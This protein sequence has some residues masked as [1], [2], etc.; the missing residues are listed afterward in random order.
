MT[1]HAAFIR[2]ICETPDDDVPRLIYADWLE[3]HGDSVERLYGEF[4][5]VQ[6]ALARDYPRYT[7]LLL[8][9][10]GRGLFE[11]NQAMREG[12][13]EWALRGMPAGLKYHGPVVWRGFVQG[14]ELRQ[15]AFLGHAGALAQAMPITGVRFPNVWPCTNGTRH[16]Y[17]KESRMAWGVHPDLYRL[18]RQPCPAA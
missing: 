5:H 13:E 6:C 4:I 2:S 9:E 3:E 18:L 11:R 15:R 17:M 1:I 7:G 12:M 8:D 16:A 14:I 10:R